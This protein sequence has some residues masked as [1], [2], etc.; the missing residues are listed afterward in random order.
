MLNTKPRCT[1]IVGH[2]INK[3]IK[4][5]NAQGNTAQLRENESYRKNEDSEG[6]SYTLIQGQVVG[7]DGDQYV[8][9]SY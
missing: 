8:K 3:I 1:L 5:A 4:L 6:N 7:S 9:S 2:A